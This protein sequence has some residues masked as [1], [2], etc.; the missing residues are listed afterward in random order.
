MIKL[1]RAIQSASRIANLVGVL[2]L[3]P[4]MLITT[5]DVILRLFFNAPVR[6]GLEMSQF[7]MVAIIWLTMAMTMQK[8]GHI[9]MELLES[10]LSKKV[11]YYSDMVIYVVLLLTMVIVDWALC[12]RMIS[13]YAQG[14]TTDVLQWPIYPALLIML[15]GGA[16]LVLEVAAELYLLLTR[17]D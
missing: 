14:E 5:T 9:S 17:R 13:S 3:V 6:G 12:E 2:L 7:V 11:L 15:I 1:V 4:L 16:L 10:R 8:K